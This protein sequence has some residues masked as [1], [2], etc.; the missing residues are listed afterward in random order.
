M[1]DLTA[2]SSTS[3]NQVAEV[4][5]SI[6]SKSPSPT[7]DKL[8]SCLDLIPISSDDESLVPKLQECSSSNLAAS[9]LTTRDLSGLVSEPDGDI[10][11]SSSSSRI[12]SRRKKQTTFYGNPI[13][14][15]VNVHFAVASQV[16]TVQV[17]HSRVIHPNESG[18]FSRKFT[19]FSSI[20]STDN[21]L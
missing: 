7:K 11:S 18:G 4:P 16:P 1:I 3:G 2:S 12:S 17:G 20:S 15:S 5:I 10:S 19:R 14:H 9:G 21:P 6:K 13:R 8:L